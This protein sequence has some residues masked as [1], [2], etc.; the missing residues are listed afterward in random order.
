MNKSVREMMRDQAQPVEVKTKK[1]L[2]GTN[3][4]R[5]KWNKTEK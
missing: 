2:K 4:T 3:T 1:K 5:D